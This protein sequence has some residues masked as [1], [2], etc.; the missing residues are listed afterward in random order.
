MGI[1]KLLGKKIKNIRQLCGM[2]QEELAER[3]DISQRALSG[4]ET[5]VNFLT[6]ETFDKIVKELNISLNDLFY[7][8]H[9]N[10]ENVLIQ[11]LRGIVERLENNPMKLREVYKVV[12]AVMSE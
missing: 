3:I 4:I 12:K 5:G 7:L 1:K 10:D 9:L 6:A 8:E 11:E 2:T